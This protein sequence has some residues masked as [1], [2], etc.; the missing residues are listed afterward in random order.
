[1]NRTVQYW[2][3]LRPDGSP[4][5][6]RFPAQRVVKQ[7]MK[8]EADGK[9]RYRM[10]RDGMVLLGKGVAEPDNRML[11]LDKVRRENLPSVGNSEGARR[12]LGLSPDEGL[13]EPTYCLFT[14]RNILALL[15]SG[16]GPRP[17]RLVDYLGAKL[18]IDISLAPVLTQNLDQVLAEMRVSAID[19]A[20]PANRISRDLVGGDWVQAL[21]GARTLAQDG[22]VRVGISVG[23]SGDAAHKQNMRTRI[24]Q[25]TELLRSSDGL[26]EFNSARVTGTI[27]GTNR[28]LNLLEDQFIE[29]TEVDADRINDPDRSVTYARD[30]LQS[31]RVRNKEYLESAVPAVPDQVLELP[32]AFVET[33]DDERQ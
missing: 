24:R 26:S 19:V 31:S 20:I 16:D 22:V 3:L 17:R 29:K 15:T 12:A 7:L 28:S 1:V 6:G 32:I 33:P 8:A 18:N 21:D 14:R 5:P 11:V 25:M 9:S 30:L 2:Q 27:Q 10:C 4:L 13:L 23:R